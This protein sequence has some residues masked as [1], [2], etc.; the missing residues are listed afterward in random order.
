MGD[1]SS[2]MNIQYHSNHQTPVS[3][4]IVLLL[5]ESSHAEVK[6]ALKL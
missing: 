4:I 1:I 2:V 5:P 6:A 3:F